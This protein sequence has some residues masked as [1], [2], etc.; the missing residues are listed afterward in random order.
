MPLIGGFAPV[1]YFTVIH[2]KPNEGS[3]VIERADVECAG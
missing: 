2:E 3:N 1:V